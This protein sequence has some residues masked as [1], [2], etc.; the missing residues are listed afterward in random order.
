MRP[1]D[2]GAGSVDAGHAGLMEAF[3]EIV[4]E[5]AVFREIYALTRG[6]GLRS[7]DA[8]RGGVEITVARGRSGPRLKSARVLGA[9]NRRRAP[10]PAS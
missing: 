5:H 10:T 3:D 1:G 7:Q 9:S 8:P 4:A 6:D 2:G